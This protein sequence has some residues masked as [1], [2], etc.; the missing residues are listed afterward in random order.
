MWTT[1]AQRELGDAVNNRAT[2][3]VSFRCINVPGE[4]QLCEIPLDWHVTTSLCS[5]RATI[6]EQAQLLGIELK[7]LLPKKTR[8]SRKRKEEGA[9]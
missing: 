9:D 4:R 1:F 8:K 2:V 5:S 7:D 6:V 3:N